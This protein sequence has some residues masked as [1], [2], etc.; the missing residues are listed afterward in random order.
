MVVAVSKGLD[1]V[2]EEEVVEEEVVV[3]GEMTATLL[4]T[5]DTR[6]MAATLV[7]Q[8]MEH[9]PAVMEDRRTRA[10]LPTR[11]VAPVT[12][13]TQPEDSNNNRCSTKL[14]LLICLQR[15]LELIHQGLSKWLPSNSSTPP[16]L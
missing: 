9:R 13:L 12:I 7:V 6:V 16:S 3:A 8:T 1:E 11:M 2:V 14:M 5:M 4:A 15:P 10:P